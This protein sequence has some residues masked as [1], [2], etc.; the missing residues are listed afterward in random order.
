MVRIMKKMRYLMEDSYNMAYSSAAKNV[1]SFMLESLLWNIED[2]W[3]LTNCGTYRK[4]FV[5]SQ[6]ISTLRKGKFLYF[7]FISIKRISFAYHRGNIQCPTQRII[8]ERN[9]W[10]IPIHFANIDDLTCKPNLKH[11]RMF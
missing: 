2:S 8:W 10:S 3:Y 11:V 4:V 1:S 9:L 7:S 6:L 5:F